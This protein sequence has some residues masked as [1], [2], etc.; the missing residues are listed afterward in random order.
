MHQSIPVMALMPYKVVF[1]TLN[2]TVG[3]ENEKKNCF[4]LHGSSEPTAETFTLV[5]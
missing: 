5:N 3:G 1:F 4:N 2:V